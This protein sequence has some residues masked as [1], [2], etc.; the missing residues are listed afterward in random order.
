MRWATRLVRLTSSCRDSLEMR[1]TSFILMAPCRASVALA[2]LRLAS[3]TS[4]QSFFRLSGTCSVHG[5]SN[6]STNWHCSTSSCY[7]QLPTI[8]ETTCLTIVEMEDWVKTWKKPQVGNPRSASQYSSH[9]NISWERHGVHVHTFWSSQHAYHSNRA[10]RQ[11][12][13]WKSR[14]LTSDK[15]GNNWNRSKSALWIDNQR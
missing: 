7:N 1:A 10:H 11:H 9:P 6:H 3:L 8:R 2:L 15:K 12:Q 14:C 4:F 5:S 13:E